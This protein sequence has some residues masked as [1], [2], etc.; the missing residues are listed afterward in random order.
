MDPMFK[1]V[2]N[3]PNHQPDDMHFAH[4]AGHIWRRPLI[5]VHYP[6]VPWRSM[7]LAWPKFHMI[8]WL[9]RPKNAVRCESCRQLQDCHMSHSVTLL[10]DFA[11]SGKES[12][13]QCDT[14]F[15]H[16]IHTILMW[17]KQFHK[18]SPSHQHFYRCYKPRPNGWFIFYCF[19]HIDILLIHV[20]L[21]E[22]QSQ[23]PASSAPPWQGLPFPPSNWKAYV[24]KTIVEE[25]HLPPPALLIESRNI[26]G[27]HDSHWCLIC[28]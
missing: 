19:S 27:R 13:P 4:F 8:P 20:Q 23:V 18:P 25:W 21:A 26:M 17:V 6:L 14:H 24:D 9:H 11:F 22:L 5:S 10:C 15:M 7:L 12:N 28:M 2:P 1:N 16:F 3:V